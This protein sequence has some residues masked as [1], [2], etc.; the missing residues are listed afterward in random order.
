M[1]LLGFLSIAVVPLG[2][3]VAWAQDNAASG[4]PPAQPLGASCLRPPAK[5]ADDAVSA[6]LTHPGVFLT[7]H[8]SGGAAMIVKVRA[9][10]GSNGQAIDPLIGLNAD[11]G[12]MQQ[13][14]LG[15]G[16]SEAAEVCAKVQPQLSAYIRST[17]SKLPPGNLFAAFQTSE[18]EFAGIALGPVTLPDAV[19]DDTPGDGPNGQQ[20]H[21]RSS[22]H[23]TSTH[24][25]TS[26]SVSSGGAGAATIAN[27]VSP[28]T[29]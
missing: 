25:A 24:A 27:D 26:F 19:A 10:A 1:R 11:A 14:A 20:P 22:R 9:L 5:L 18:N 21:I 8:P 29:L 16:L 4:T 17:V 6:F 15:I 12:A 28:T 3:G 13:R 7:D 23:T 2:V